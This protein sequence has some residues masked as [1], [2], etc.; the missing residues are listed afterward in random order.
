MSKSKI[1]FIDRDGTLI[2]EPD[3]EQI[4][5]LAKL[6]LE[7]F[8]IPALLELQR[9]GFKLV[10]ISNQDALGSKA[11]PYKKFKVAHDKMLDLFKSQGIVFSDIKIC[12][13]SERDKCECR[14][15]KLGLVLTYMQ[16]QMFDRDH[17]YV[18]GDRKTDV[19]LA[20]NMGV[21]GI[22]YSKKNNWLKIVNYI[23]TQNRNAKVRRV[24]T[25]TSI[26]VVVD[27]AA[28]IP[29]EIKTGIG[30]FDHMLEQ[31][32]KHGGFS[33]VLKVKGDTHVDEHHTVE[34][35]ALALGQALSEALGDKL[36]IQRYGFLL[37]MDESLAQVAIDLSGRPFLVFNCSFNREVINNFPT[38]LVEH[39]FR[40]LADSLRA[41]INI[42][43]E[44][45]NAHHLIESIFKGVGRAL[46]MAIKQDGYDVPSTKGVL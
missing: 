14:K 35:T 43:A 7:P 37:P 15:P 8:V 3:D 40:S 31:L 29:I 38:E 20:K 23:L 41:T 39:F 6:Q 12:P 19:E 9:A 27:L 16:Q 2:D 32:A 28:K 26:N 30:F 45:E 11:F 44:G 13:H 42:K 1:L 4:D 17:S 24:T 5:S 46:G 25:E 10:M 34:D 33:L 18:I 22:H 36:G 21:K